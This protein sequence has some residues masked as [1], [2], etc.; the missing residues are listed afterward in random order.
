MIRSLW[1]LHRSACRHCGHGTPCETGRLIRTLTPPW[2]K[3]LFRWIAFN[4]PSGR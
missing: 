2:Y 3:R 1:S 4:W